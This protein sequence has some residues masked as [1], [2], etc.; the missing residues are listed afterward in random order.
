LRV[1][2]D[3]NVL[4]AAFAT[5]GLCAD[6]LRV[7]LVRH[8]LV[9]ADVVLDGCRALKREIGWTTNGSGGWSSCSSVPM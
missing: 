7:V 8:E 2:L 6:L 5:R 1:F 4:V 9:V 3:T